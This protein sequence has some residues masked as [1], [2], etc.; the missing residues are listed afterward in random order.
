MMPKLRF[1]LIAGVSA[2]GILHS[3]SVEVYDGG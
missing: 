3:V 2:L 1:L